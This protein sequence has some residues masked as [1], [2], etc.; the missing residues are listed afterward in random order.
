MPVSAVHGSGEDRYVF[1][2]NKSENTFG[3]TEMT[4]RK[5]SVVVE[6]EVDGVASLQDD[7]S[8]YTLAY[9]EDRAISDGDSVMEYTD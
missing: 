9:M 7:I 4:V 5:M 6:A 2:I 8:W 3:S 1:V